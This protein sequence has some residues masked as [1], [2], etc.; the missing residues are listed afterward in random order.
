MSYICGKEPGFLGSG[1]E[2][3]RMEKHQ[4]QKDDYV[5]WVSE[6]KTAYGYIEEV[7]DDQ[8]K[9]HVRDRYFFEKSATIPLSSLVYLPPVL[10]TEEDQKRFCRY[11]ISLKELLHGNAE[12]DYQLV[13]DYRVCL[14]DLLE[15][16]RTIREKNTAHSQYEEEWLRPLYVMFYD[17]GGIADLLYS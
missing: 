2:V 4:F 12:A 9:I 8:A 5:S 13:E 14:Y 16:F 7:I 6:N 1:M 11:E 3:K 10:L 15:A 17:D